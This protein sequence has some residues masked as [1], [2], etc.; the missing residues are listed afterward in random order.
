MTQTKQENVFKPI[1]SREMQILQL[2]LL[3]AF[4]KA[5]RKI[6]RRWDFCPNFTA[7]WFLQ[8]MLC[9]ARKVCSKNSL[10][11]NLKARAPLLDVDVLDNELTI[12]RE[13]H[14]CSWQGHHL[15]SSLWRQVCA[16]YNSFKNLTLNFNRYWNLDWGV[17]SGALCQDKIALLNFRESHVA[18]LT[19]N[20]HQAKTLRGDLDYN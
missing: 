12:Q 9:L 1:K 8:N 19:L 5:V 4:G 7:S 17:D 13:K 14:S 18:L 11:A 15:A 2:N 10:H 3:L 20:R 6:A 16:F